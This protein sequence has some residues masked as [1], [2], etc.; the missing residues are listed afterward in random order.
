MSIVLLEPPRPENP[1]RLEDV[2]NAP[3]SACLFTGY[4][5]SVLHKNKIEAEIINAHL[6]N[7]SMEKT[8]SFLSSKN[9]P[10]LCVHAV[11]L[12]ERTQNVFDMLSAIKS[13]NKA[14]HINLYG[15][16][17]T[18]AY[19]KILE[20][21]PHIDSVTIGEPEFTA[22]ELAQH[23]SQ[24]SAPDEIHIPGLASRN[25]QGNVVFSPRPP[26]Q[27]LDQLPYPDRQDIDLYKKKGI[28]TYIQ[29]SR[30]CYGHCTFCYLNPFYGQVNLWRGR[31]AKNIFEE[32]L[33]LYTE[34][35]INNFYFSDANFLGPG[36]HGRGRA[37]TLAE[38]ILMHDININFGFEC[39]V[40][41]IEEHSLS[42]LVMAGLTNVF[43]GLESGD[44]ESLSRFN[45]N[46]SV[47]G[48]KRAI[49]LL[50][51]YGIEPTYG[52]I[53]FEPDSTLKSVRNNFEFLKETNIMTTP[54]VTAHL[55]HHKETILKGTPDY[56]SITNKTTCSNSFT[57]YEAL[58]K[59]RNPEVEAFSEIIT[60]V[61]K[62][63]LSLLPAVHNCQNA[64]TDTGI[65]SDSLAKLNNILIALFEKT[66]SDFEKNNLTYSSDSIKK[67]TQELI[68]EVERAIK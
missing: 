56:L 19:K 37:V 7:W 58:Y 48:N 51:D 43:L 31:S 25:N 54:A 14:M 34:Y 55:L 23:I 22:L 16:Y 42:M 18:F 67:L 21:F 66:L 47:E 53:M 27:D 64:A 17:P 10:L 26:V 2:V 3:L 39:R 12:W 38:L 9:I 61:C 24:N 40:N 35:S 28:V 59:I 20:D 46:T 60:N 13:S 57:N 32:I 62:K 65:N 68:H 11:Y 8:V 36:K 52:F 15:Y 6:Y 63:A 29:G 45:K 49:Q 50:R 4:I 5:F 30:G 33:K 41:D 44:P 1:N